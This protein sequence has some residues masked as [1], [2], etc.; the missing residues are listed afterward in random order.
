MAY[1]RHEAGIRA[2]G[3]RLRQL[4]KEK[5]LSQEA[6]AFA[7]DIELSQISRME[8]GIINTSIS[9][10]FQIAQALGVSPAALFEFHLE[11]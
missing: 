9:Q 4:R 10:V 1:T 8:R 11:A 6:L 2:F 5:G 3:Q 7:A